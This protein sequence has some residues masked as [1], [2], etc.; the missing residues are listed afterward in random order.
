MSS[1][2]KVFSL[3]QGE[4]RTLVVRILKSDGC[5]GTEAYDLSGVTE[6]TAVF[7]KSDK[8]KL[9]KL[10]SLSEVSIIS[11][12]AG[13]IQVNLSDTD[14]ALLATGKNQDFALILQ[15]G[16]ETRE[17]PFEDCLEVKRSIC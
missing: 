1:S 13:K 7:K 12:I 15:S 10:L 11:P 3:I 14:T 9:V 2:K 8:T 16:L 4:D 5:G 17:I 6:V